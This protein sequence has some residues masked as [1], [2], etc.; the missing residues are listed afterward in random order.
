MSCSASTMQYSRPGFDPSDILLDQLEKQVPL[1]DTTHWMKTVALYC[2]IVLSTVMT[3]LVG[4]FKVSLDKPKTTPRLVETACQTD[5]EDWLELECDWNLCVVGHK[6]IVEDDTQSCTTEATD[7]LSDV[8]NETDE[9]DCDESDDGSDDGSDA[10][11]IDDFEDFCEYT[12]DSDCAAQADVL[13]RLT[14]T[15]CTTEDSQCVSMYLEAYLCE[16]GECPQYKSIVQDVTAATHF[17]HNDQ[18]R[19]SIVR[20]LQAFSTYNEVIG[21]HPGMISTARECL[22]MW[23]GDEDRAFQ[24]FA[25]VYDAMPRLC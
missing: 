21:Y 2:T 23:H 10:E 20:L 12:C 1:K 5:E 18:Q 25:A 15:V 6:C 14:A 3:L 11:S 22:Q 13:M 4:S 9:E 19:R 8:E 7:L 17:W 16:C 24:S